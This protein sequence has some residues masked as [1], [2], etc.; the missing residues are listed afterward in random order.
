MHENIHVYLVPMP[1]RVHECVL[2]CQD[3]Y[4][5]YLDEKLSHE[6]RIEK[7]KHAVDEHIAKNHFEKADV[8]T[9]EAEA[10]RKE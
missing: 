2:P 3:G 7:Y 4:T 1:E 10:H 5:V 8:Q 9:I 6:Q